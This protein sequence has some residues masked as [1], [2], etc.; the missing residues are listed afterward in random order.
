MHDLEGQCVHLAVRTPELGGSPAPGARGARVRHRRLQAQLAV[1][2]G[3]LTG[4]EQMTIDHQLALTEHLPDDPTLPGLLVVLVHGSLDRAASF[5]RVT[6]RLSDLHT[7]AY[8]RQ[9]YH[10]SR[11]GLPA[12]TSLD[13]HIDDL[14]S[15][16]DGRP[17]VVVGHSYGGTLALGAALRPGSRGLILAVAAYEP[18]MPWL[19]NWATRGGTRAGRSPAVVNED[20]GDAAEGFFRRMVG[21]AAWDRLPEKTKEARRADGEALAAELAAIRVDN[22]PFDIPSLSVPA[23]FGRGTESLPHHRDAVGWLVEHVP[24]SELFEI[25]GAAHGA[26]L[27]HPDAFADFVRAAVARAEPDTGAVGSDRTRGR[28]AGG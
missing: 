5:A 7:V 10:R 4:W 25:E 19:G 6:R 17:S 27:T 18:P 8:D 28:P 11:N 3:T 15:V 12:H 16:I 1:H 23:V 20:P 2:P 24:G 13:G 22:P 14:L 26:H 21:D 9:G